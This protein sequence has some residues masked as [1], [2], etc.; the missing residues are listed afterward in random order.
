MVRVQHAESNV[1]NKDTTVAPL[2]FD[3]KNHTVNT[4][5]AANYPPQS[6]NLS[7]S[8][9]ATH[10]FL[11]V[12]AYLSLTHY[13]IIVILV[14]KFPASRRRQLPGHSSLWP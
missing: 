12:L 14:D 1:A 9:A 7:I 4:I 10:V 6:T 11:L 3:T 8:R 5:G 13:R 2:N